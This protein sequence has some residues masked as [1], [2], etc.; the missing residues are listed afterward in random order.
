MTNLKFIP[1]KWAKIFNGF[2]VID[3]GETRNFIT[4]EIPVRDVSVLIEFA[5]FFESDK[6]T[7]VFSHR[8]CAMN[9]KR[10]NHNFIII[11]I[12]EQY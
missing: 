1:R 8:K 5:Q 12:E 2:A 11:Q 10:M 6:K 3:Y 9:V 4:C 7:D